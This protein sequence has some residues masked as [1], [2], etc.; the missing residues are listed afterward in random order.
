MDPKRH[1]DLLK[2]RLEDLEEN[3]ELL[4]SIVNNVERISFHLEEIPISNEAKKAFNLFKKSVFRVN[5]NLPIRIRYTEKK[6][7]EISDLSD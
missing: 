5:E 6:L 3:L 7:D 1:K 4:H 2:K